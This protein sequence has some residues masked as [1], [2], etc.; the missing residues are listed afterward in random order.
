MSTNL[1]FEQLSEDER[2][3]F[4][5]R[6][7]AAIEAFDENIDSLKMWKREFSEHFFNEPI[8]WSLEVKLGLS[9][10]RSFLENKNCDLTT[11]ID[12]EIAVCEIQQYK[13]NRIGRFAQETLSPDGFTAENIFVTYFA[14][15][16]LKNGR[17]PTR[18]SDM[19]EVAFNPRKDSKFFRVFS[20]KKLDLISNSNWELERSIIVE[21]AEEAEPVLDRRDH[22]VRHRS[23]SV[24]S[25]GSDGDLEYTILEEG[26]FEEF[27]EVITEAL[28]DQSD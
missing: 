21:P 25:T 23:I 18:E 14:W 4:M 10:L 15:E 26:G 12:L 8:Y 5:G 7:D 17:Y 1:E 22:L 11:L 13:L 2:L 27:E 3:L 19:V 6:V 20:I 28:D 16:G 24:P 9:E